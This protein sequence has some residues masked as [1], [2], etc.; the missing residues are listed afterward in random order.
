MKMPPARLQAL[1]SAKGGNGDDR[2]VGGTESPGQ[3]R[4]DGPQAIQLVRAEFIT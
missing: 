2:V 4:E 3:T 1:V